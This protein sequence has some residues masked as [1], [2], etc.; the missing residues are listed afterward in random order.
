MKPTR[1]IYRESDRAI[2]FQAQAN[3]MREA[4]Q[5]AI[6]NGVSLAGAWLD[7]HDLTGLNARKADFTGARMVGTILDACDFTLAGMDNLVA[8]VGNARHAKFIETSMSNAN[9]DDRDLS[10][11]DFTDAVTTNIS[12]VNT[13]RTL[14]ITSPNNSVDLGAAA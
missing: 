5:L 13:I 8:N 6:D 11:T 7:G 2:L 1:V 9:L 14:I 4:V 10:Y 3:T 12:V